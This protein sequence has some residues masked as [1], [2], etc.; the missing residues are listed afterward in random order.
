MLVSNARK[1]Y[2]FLLIIIAISVSSYYAQKDLISFSAPPMFGGSDQLDYNNMAFSMMKKNIPGTMITD[3]YKEPF[4][5]FANLKNKY[6]SRVLNAKNKDLRPYAYRP[7]L[8]S[9]VLGVNYKLFGYSFSVARILNIFFI[10]LGTVFLFLLIRSLTNE[11]IAL[12]GALLY[13][14]LPNVIKYSN[15]LLS[16]VF[17]VTMAIIFLFLL[18]KSF[19]SSSK[20]YWFLTGLFLGLLVLSKQMFYL[21]SIPL[22]L[23]I[24]FYLI[25]NKNSETIYYLLTPFFLLIFPWFAYNIAI[26][27]NT[28]LKTGTSGWHDMPSAYSKGYYE[29]KNRFKIR[30]EIFQK[31]EEKHNVKIK[32]DIKRSIYGKK[33]FFENIK[34]KETLSLLPELMYF[35]VKKSLTSNYFTYLALFIISVISLLYLYKIHELSI[36]IL[37][38]SMIAYMNI[39]IVAVTFS[40]NGRLISSTFPIFIILGT[41]L[42]YHLY[43][44]RRIAHV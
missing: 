31:Y 32:G 5:K 16:E 12:G 17:V 19:L 8:Y 39:A 34:K 36:Y 6:I 2:L 26:T 21:V 35:K 18:Q 11:H 29:G 9:I 4:K 14:L 33:I 43:E 10:V 23:L 13:L 22:L 27:G 24:I 1:T 40:D 3:E 15:L 37:I 38:I 30:E 7:L 44:R 41:V 42:V 28:S 25:K 20:K